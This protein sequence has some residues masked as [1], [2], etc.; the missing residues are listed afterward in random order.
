MLPAHRR[1]GG[2]PYYKPSHG[3]P[4]LLGHSLA[5]GLVAW[6]AF[7]EGSGSLVA[8]IIGNRHGKW[9]GA[10]G[11]ND[12]FWR[13][14][15]LGGAG[16]HHPAGTS[17][18]RVVFSPVLVL[19][20]SDRY[21]IEAW[22][23]RSA[24]GGTFQVLLTQNFANG[25]YQNTSSVQLFNAGASTGA[26]VVGRWNHVV[27]T[28][29]GSV[30]SYYINGRLS[31]TVSASV[32]F[33]ADSMISDSGGESLSGGIDTVRVWKGR[34]LTAGDVLNLYVE[35]M[36]LAVPVPPHRSHPGSLTV[37]RNMLLPAEMLS[38]LS[39][40]T[41]LPVE[42]SGVHDLSRDMLLPVEFDGLRA[43]VRSMG[44]PVEI[45][46]AVVASKLL[47]VEFKQ[48]VVQVLRGFLLPVEV[49]GLDPDLLLHIWDDL[50]LLAAPFSHDWN[51]RSMAQ[52]FPLL[53]E[54]TVL[55]PP[56]PLPHRWNVTG[57]ILTP[58]GVD[59]DTGE[60]IPPP[61]PGA[62]APGDIQLPTT[63]K[64]KTP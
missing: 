47:P 10:T 63:V 16:L 14:G 17:T 19:G 8:D 53:H 29:T 57:D 44:L 50:V 38:A 42:F 5:E 56:P 52:E 48:N 20:S 59:P 28:H 61:S 60:P 64:D 23:F 2:W 21:S 36:G 37:S 26:T 58:F 62:V 25:L 4:V 7:R 41:L 51:V 39:R 1:S 3:S 35:P 34:I 22:F 31:N 45:L 15:R 43:L 49:G 54:W 32:A 13:D 11:T 6:W 18:H 24:I 27:V 55:E 30:I 9:T 40:L 33:S 46:Q 12:M